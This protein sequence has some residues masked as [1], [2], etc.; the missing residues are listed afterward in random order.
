MSCGNKLVLPKLREGQ[1]L[2]GFMIHKIFKSTAVYIRPS[3]ILPVPVSFLK[4]RSSSTFYFD[5]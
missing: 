4:I 2:N 3:S 5:F 1:E